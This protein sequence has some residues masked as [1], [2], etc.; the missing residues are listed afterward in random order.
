MSQ[1]VEITVKSQLTRITK[2]LDDI[3]KMYGEAE[4]GIKKTGEQV[5]DQVRKSAKNAQDGVAQSASFMKRAFVGLKDDIK[6]LLSV[7]ALA[8]SLKLSNTMRGTITDT[9]VLTDTVRKLSGVFKIATGDQSKFVGNLTKG[10]G[11]IGLGSDAAARA[12]QGLS[13]T[14]VRGQGNLQDYTKTAGMLAGATNQKG[15]EGAIAQGLAGVLQAQGKDVND[16]KSMA[17]VADQVNRAH[18]ATGGSATEILSSMQEMFSSMDS[19]LKSRMTPQ[20]MSQLEVMGK[21]GGKG[22]TDFIKSYL[23]TN[24]QTRAGLDALGFGKLFTGQGLNQKA[25]SGIIG[26]AKTLGLNGNPTAGLTNMGLGEDQA[27]GLVMLYDN[28]KEVNRAA[29]EVSKSTKTVADSFEDTKTMGDSFKGNLDKIK[30]I[31]AQPI[32]AGTGMLTDLFK[33]TQK[34][35]VGSAAVVGGSAILAGVLAKFG[36]GGIGSALGIKNLGERAAEAKGEK[37]QKVHVTNFAEVNGLG[38]GSLLP[39]LAGGAALGGA[40]LLGTAVVGSAAAMYYNEK[41][42]AAQTMEPLERAKAKEQ[43]NADVLNDLA[44]L[45]GAI[46]HL[47]MAVKRPQQVHLRHPEFR[48]S[49]PSSTGAN[50]SGVK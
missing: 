4:E 9:V 45:P 10:L 39:K 1:P 33:T 29:Q 5:D 35:T 8:G 38:G 32:A 25:L 11:D 48:K 15:Q 12:L 17:I 3:V 20:A 16:T 14:Q 40:A 2:E 49:P 44:A 19:T 36:L 37:V 41:K 7:Q 24:S 47:S 18:N 23:G 50:N 46:T 13:E 31:F 21:A 43:E 22:S 26:Q 34:S 30:S 28:L 6:A 27:K 42:V